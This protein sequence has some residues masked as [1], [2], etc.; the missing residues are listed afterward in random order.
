MKRWV[1]VVACVCVGGGGVGVSKEGNF[2][3]RNLCGFGAD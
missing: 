3:G 1:V 2:I